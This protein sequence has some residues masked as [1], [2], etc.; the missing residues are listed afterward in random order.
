MSPGLLRR[1]VILMAVATFAMFTVS[2]VVTQFRDAPPG[3]YQV[4]QG[5]LR[6]SEQN[7]NEALA[8]FDAALEQAPHHRGAMMGRAI[9]FLQ[10][11]EFAKAEAAFTHLIAYLTHNL[12]ADDATGIAVLAGAY[13]NRGI[14]YDRTDRHEQALG[15]YLQA[16]K[17]DKDAVK[18]PNLFHRILYGNTRPATI[19]KRTEYLAIQLALPEDQRVL[20]DP[21]RDRAQRMYKP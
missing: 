7:Y 21:E 12:E 1:Y 15:D 3:D 14:L 18:G 6:L 8:A 10:T 20:R 13:A 19:A 5:D 2:A 17:T 9:V 16:L 4:R 11:G